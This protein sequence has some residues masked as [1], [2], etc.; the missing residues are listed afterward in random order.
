MLRRLAGHLGRFLVRA[1]A[2]RHPH[3]AALDA[4]AVLHPTARISNNRGD[5][6]AIRVGRHSHIRGELLTFGHGGAIE[7]GEYC[8]IGEQTRLWSADR[9][10]VGNRTL[11][12]HQVTILDNETH[13]FSAKARHEQFRAIITSGHPAEYDLGERPVVIGE[14]VLIGC[15]CVVLPGVRIGNEAIVGAGSVVTKDVPPRTIVAGN[16]ARIIRELRDDER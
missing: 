12:S 9:I 10:V 15:M 13:P 6:N 7:V 3:D 1:A 14:D 16:P 8:Y 5:P 2:G 4:T 11:I